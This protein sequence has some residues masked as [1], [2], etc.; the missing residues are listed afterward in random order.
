MD[1][2]GLLG[3]YVSVTFAAVHGIESAPVPAFSA[4][5]A[6]ET[7]R[8]AVRCALEECYIDF[9]AIVTGVLFLCV[10]HRC[11]EQQAGGENGESLAHV[12]VLAL[13]P[14]RRVGL[15]ANS[16]ETPTPCACAKYVL[17]Y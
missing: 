17:E 11:P 7:F 2:H 14:V 15:C 8:G 9:V 13:T 12:H 4:D 1:A 16:C 3:N 5:V 10:D 6:V